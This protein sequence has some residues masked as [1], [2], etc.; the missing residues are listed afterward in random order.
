M[1][2]KLQKSAQALTLTFLL[3]SCASTEEP[4]NFQC[5]QPETKAIK[6]KPI[7]GSCTLDNG[8]M[9]YYNEITG[10]QF[11]VDNFKR[12]FLVNKAK[13]SQDG[14]FYF[15]NSNGSLGGL[16]GRK[17]PNSGVI[18]VVERVDTLFENCPSLNIAEQ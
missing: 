10:Q 4:N 8:V 2:K 9:N 15:S 6:L 7:P 12:G 18:E 16:C 11:V 1:I 17:A 13:T 5:S 3:S 14:K